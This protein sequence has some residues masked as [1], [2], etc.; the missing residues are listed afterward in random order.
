MTFPDGNNPYAPYSSVEDSTDVSDA[1]Q[2]KKRIR[3]G[4]SD[5][6]TGKNGAKKARKSSREDSSS[7]EEEDDNEDSTTPA[8]PDANKTYGKHTKRRVAT[9]GSSSSVDKKPRRTASSKT[10]SS[11]EEEQEEK[12][13]EFDPN[14]D[15]NAVRSSDE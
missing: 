1:P 5:A 13:K 6:T 2:A 4:K 11:S 12:D 15:K 7:D 9:P 14:H 3:P 10:T 8:T